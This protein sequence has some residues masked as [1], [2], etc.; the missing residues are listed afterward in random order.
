MSTSLDRSNRSTHTHWTAISLCPLTHEVML[1]SIS[2]MACQDS[3]VPKSIIKTAHACPSRIGPH[4]VG[5]V[6]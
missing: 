1:I 2:N 5:I 3:L 4:L 6:N